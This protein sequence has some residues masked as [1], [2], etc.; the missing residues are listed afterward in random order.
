MVIITKKKQEADT[1]LSK[2]EIEYKIEIA[3]QTL[4][5]NIGFVMNCDNKA[6]IALAVF[7]GLL[8]IVLTSEGFFAL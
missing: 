4:E 6:S 3:T 2:E 1:I 8:A 5:R 7:G